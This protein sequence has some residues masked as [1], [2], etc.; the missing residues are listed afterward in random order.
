VEAARASLC[1]IEL[2]AAVCVSAR[3]RQ[4][5]VEQSLALGRQDTLENFQEAC[6]YL[7]QYRTPRASQTLALAAPGDGT[8]Q[9]GGQPAL[10]E[11]SRAYHAAETTKVHQAVLAV[12]YRTDLAHLHD[13][14]LRALGALSPGAMIREGPAVRARPREA[15][16]DDTRA[17]A[18]EQMFGACY[19]EL[20]GTPR[21]SHPKLARRFRTTLEHAEKWHELREAC[22][23]GMLALV[24]RGANTW[25]EKLPFKVVPVY[26]RLV[27]AVNGAAM[28]LAERLG[29]YVLCISRR[30]D[31]PGQ[32]L[33]IGA[34]STAALALH[35]HKEALLL[36]GSTD[37][38]WVG[39]RTAAGRAVTVA[40]DV[41]ES[42][43]VA[44]K[45]VFSQ[46]LR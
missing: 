4:D 39:H 31:L 43:A 38:G 15:F 32:P 20:R 2:T 45:A 35:P 30:E 27:A 13:A 7:R 9:R 22:G 12:L 8:R 26:L 34:A 44:L 46:G 14:Y 10:D 40:A 16:A 5:M 33:D 23:I 37:E 6:D 18:M 28:G 42:D 19:P 3:Y 29:D 1:R 21:S 25:F 17:A 11:F 36:E 24:P 41:D